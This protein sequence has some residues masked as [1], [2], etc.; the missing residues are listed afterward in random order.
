MLYQLKGRLELPSAAPGSKLQSAIH[1]MAS[2]CIWFPFELFHGK[3]AWN[4]V[5]WHRGH[6]GGGAGGLEPPPPLLVNLVHTFD[7]LHEHTIPENET[8]TKPHIFLS[9]RWRRPVHG[10]SSHTSWGRENTFTSLRKKKILTLMSQPY[11]NDFFFRNMEYNAWSTETHFNCLCL[12]VCS[13]YILYPFS[14]VESVI[15]CIPFHTLFPL[16]C[17]D[18]C[19]LVN[20]H[21]KCGSLTLHRIWLRVHMPASIRLCN[22]RRSVFRHVFCNVKKISE[23]NCQR[24]R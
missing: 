17:N 24:S 13:L 5:L 20:K 7:F 10:Y 16:Y 18:Y 19:T 4:I 12:L 21:D 22:E 15:C 9:L 8:L 6:E 3:P 23:V 11:Q 14:Y 2:R 1:N